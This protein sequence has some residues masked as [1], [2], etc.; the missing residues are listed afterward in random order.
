[1]LSFQGLN[2]ESEFFIQ[3]KFRSFLLNCKKSDL[4]IISANFK[5]HSRNYFTAKLIF[6]TSSSKDH[7]FLTVSSFDPNSLLKTLRKKLYLAIDEINAPSIKNSTFDMSPDQE[8]YTQPLLPRSPRILIV[9]DDLDSAAPLSFI[10]SKLGCQTNFATKAF[11]AQ[12]RIVNFL[13]DLIILDWLLDRG[14]AG[15]VI[16]A[17]NKKA[18]KHPLLDKKL[19][20]VQPKII[21]CSGLSESKISLPHLNHLKHIAHWQ[22]PFSF[23]E[24]SKK[25]SEILISMGL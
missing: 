6:A 17:I 1:M 16:E 2:E 20:L 11:E 3:K 15:L 8:E 5:E 7:N 23:H 24:A 22:K 25:S 18:R 12:H 9:D 10:F 14:D 19:F 13:P 4:K 21:T